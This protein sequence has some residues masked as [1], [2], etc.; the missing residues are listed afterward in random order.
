VHADHLTPLG[1]RHKCQECGYEGS[2]VIEADSLEDA[3]RIR[4]ELQAQLEEASEEPDDGD[5]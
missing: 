5:E 3:K 4:E 1:Q 2:F